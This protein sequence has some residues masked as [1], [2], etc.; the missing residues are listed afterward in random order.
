MAANGMHILP[1][2]TMGIYPDGIVADM[3][4]GEDH[5]HFGISGFYS[6][7]NHHSIRLGAGYRYEDLYEVISRSNT[8]LGLN[9]QPLPPG[10]PMVDKSDTPFSVYPEALRQNWYVF[11]QD[12]WNLHPQWDV[13]LGLR[14]DDYSDFGHTLNPCAALVWQA[15]PRLAVKL[16]YGEAFRAPSFREMYLSN[17]PQLLGN[18]EVKPETIRTWELVLDWRVRDNLNLMLTPYA[19]RI[20]DKILATPSPA[21][22]NVLV[23]QN[24]GEQ[25]GYGMEFEA[26][27]K[28]T[29]KSSVLFNYSLVH[30]EINGNAVAVYPQQDAYLRVDWLVRP[31]WYL[32]A[33][34]N[35]VGQRE[36]APNSPR[37]ALDGYTTVDLTL[38]Y[39]N[40]HADHWNIAI[41]LRNLLDSD[42]RDPGELSSEIPLA[43]RNGFVEARY[44]FD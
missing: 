7:F 33:Q 12:T 4:S 19:Y 3:K 26:R 14:Y 39:K 34:M 32:D 13:T 28:M 1:P 15:A 27:W 24:A 16:L 6:G 10:S 17:N 25:Q 43:G 2:G 29:K 42:A 35:W 5:L 36:R 18:R 23:I 40:I 37:P 44:R 9:G 30:P 41:G 21:H 20:Q 8:G 38:R 11:A 31:N 22:D